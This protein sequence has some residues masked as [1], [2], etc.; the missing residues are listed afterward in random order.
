MS[1]SFWTHRSPAAFL[2]AHLPPAQ[3]L[4][5]VANRQ[6]VQLCE[7]L[8]VALIGYGHQE[9]PGAASSFEED[10]FLRPAPLPSTGTTSF[11]RHRARAISENLQLN[12]KR[13]ISAGPEA[14]LHLSLRPSLGKIQLDSKI[15]YAMN[16][17]YLLVG[18]ALLP[19]LRKSLVH[20]VGLVRVRVG[21]RGLGGQGD[22][23]A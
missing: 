14:V 10:H 18:P 3:Q 9:R 17:T 16:E 1:A 13:F 8:Q 5:Q 19:P 23:R 15:P 21:V 22:G 7:C 20:G 4:Q 2:R 6:L 12:S 11:D